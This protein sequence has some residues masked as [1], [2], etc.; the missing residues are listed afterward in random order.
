[1]MEALKSAQAVDG[2]DRGWGRRLAGMMMDAGFEVH[3]TAITR[4]QPSQRETSGQVEESRLLEM[5]PR[6]QVQLPVDEPAWRELLVAYRNGICPCVLPGS[7]NLGS[8][9][10]SR[11]HL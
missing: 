1:M 11:P 2:E 3:A 7:R 4:A 8:A 6:L 5:A 9:A 10:G